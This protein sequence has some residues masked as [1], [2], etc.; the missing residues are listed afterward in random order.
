MPMVSN[1]T[2]FTLEA[3]EDFPRRFRVSFLILKAFNL[4]ENYTEPVPNPIAS[5]DF[6]RIFLSGFLQ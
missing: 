6:G 3:G 4:I 1:Q 2:T 5:P